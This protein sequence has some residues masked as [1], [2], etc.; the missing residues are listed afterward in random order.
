MTRYPWRFR[1]PEG[2]SN[3]RQHTSG[4]RCRTCEE[5][6]DQDDLVDHGQTR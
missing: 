5:T 6:F 4:F 2:H 1:C 3:L